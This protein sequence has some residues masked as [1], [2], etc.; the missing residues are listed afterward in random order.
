MVRAITN[1]A[2]TTFNKLYLAHPAID[3]VREAK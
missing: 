3:R 1:G 2:I